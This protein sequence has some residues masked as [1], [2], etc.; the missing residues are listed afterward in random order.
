[1]QGDFSNLYAEGFIKILTGEK[2]KG[3]LI[4]IRLPTHQNKSEAETEDSAKLKITKSEPN[5]FGFCILVTRAGIEPAIP[6]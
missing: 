6:P 5:G 4:K 3:N 2:K 1:M